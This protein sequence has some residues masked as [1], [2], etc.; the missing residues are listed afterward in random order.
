MKGVEPSPQNILVERE[1]ARRNCFHEKL[2][3]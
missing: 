2:G 3:T 1:I